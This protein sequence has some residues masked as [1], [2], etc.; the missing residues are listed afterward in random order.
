M[1]LYERWL[2]P[3]LIDLAMRNKEVMR[4]R[5]KLVPAAAGSVLEIGAGSGLNLP[6]Y[7][8]QVHRLHALD[9]SA[10]LLR[11]ARRKVSGLGFPV[12]LVQGSAAQIPLADG[13]VD[14]VVSTW[15]LCSIADVAKAL[16]ELRRVLKPGGSL[17]FVEHGRAPDAGVAR[18]QDRIEPVWKPLAGGCHLTRRIDRLIAEAGFEVDE[19]ENEYLKGPRPM[20]YTYCGRAR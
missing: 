6:I 5:R 9:P 13:S 16:R 19:L 8:P 20:T 12:E 11:M 1:G 7:G 2:L 10:S 14:T 15:T 3:R 18:W 4:Y 17:L